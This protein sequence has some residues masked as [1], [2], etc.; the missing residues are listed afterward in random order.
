MRYM[1]Y[2]REYNKNNTCTQ[3]YNGQISRQ[4][5]QQFNSLTICFFFLHKIDFSLIKLYAEL[6]YIYLF[7]YVWILRFVYFE[8]YIKYNFWHCNFDVNCQSSKDGN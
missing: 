1:Y 5:R 4:E 2:G 3:N 6:G 7:L 8:L